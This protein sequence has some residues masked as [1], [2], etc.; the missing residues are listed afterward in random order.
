MRKAARCEAMK[1]ITV[2]LPE[3]YIEALEV[4]VKAGYYPNKAEAIRTAVRDLII[5]ELRHLEAESDKL[6]GRKY[7]DF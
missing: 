1:P 5:S 6:W 4:L 3:A 7:A 2:H